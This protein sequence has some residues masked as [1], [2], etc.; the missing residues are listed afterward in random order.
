MKKQQ[1]NIAMFIDCDNVSSKY[2]ESIFDDLSQYGTVNIRRAYGD[3][4]DKKL[5]GWENILQD[6][7]IKPIQQF[8]YTKGKNATDIAMIID[9]MDILYTKELEAVVLITSDSDFTPIVTRILSDGL[10]VY[11]YGESKTPM[12]FVNACS[13]FIYVEKLNVLLNDKTIE[14]IDTNNKHHAVT[15]A[16]T[17]YVGNNYDI[18]K[19]YKLI[20]ILKQGVEVTSDEQGWADVKDMSLYIRKNSSFSQVNYGFKKMGDLIKALDLFDMEYVG[21][22]KTQL[23]IRIRDKRNR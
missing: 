7:N 16:V 3:W 18:R 2:I 9:I 1:N 21:E 22:R 15:E 23:M 12:A 19:D 17:K 4:K 14:D 20:N 11:G 8:A 6:Y 5:H 13:Q 10:T